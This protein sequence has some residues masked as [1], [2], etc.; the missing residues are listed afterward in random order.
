MERCEEMRRG[1]KR[2][3]ERERGD[4]KKTDDKE[5]AAEGLTNERSQLL[6]SGWQSESRDLGVQSRQAT[7]DTQEE[8][9]RATGV[10]T[11]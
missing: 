10:Y 7:G 8:R 4:E 5:R 9:E 6:I 1:E 2:K 11:S 3:R